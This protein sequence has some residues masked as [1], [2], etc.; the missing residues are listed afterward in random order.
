MK[1]GLRRNRL[2]EL[3]FV[4]KRVR[5]VQLGPYDM[6]LYR[7]PSPDQP[8]CSCSG[9]GGRKRQDLLLRRMLTPSLLE[10]SV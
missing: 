1:M 5:L 7:H 8:K 3:F 2:K 10:E 4:T 9:V 6:P